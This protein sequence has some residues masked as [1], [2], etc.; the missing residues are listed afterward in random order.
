MNER[1]LTHI[2][3]V[4]L[5]AGLALFVGLIVY[6]DAAEVGAA[7]SVAGGGVVIVALFH[8]LPIGLDAIG[9]WC[10][11]PARER[12]RIR[13][14]VFARWIGYS[15]NGLLPVMQVGGNVVRA[16]LLARRGVPGVL[17][18][19]SVVVDVTTLVFSQ[20][21]FALLGFALLFA[22]LGAATPALPVVTGIGFMAVLV[23]AFYVAQRRGLFGGLIHNLERVVRV[24]GWFSASAEALDGAV[25]VLYARRRATTAATAWHLVSWVVG[26]G[27]VWIALHLL[28]RPTTFTTALLIESLGQVVRSLGFAIPGA[29]GVQEA[30]YVVLGRMADLG[31]ETSLALSL[32]QRVRDLLLGLPGLLVWWLEG[33]MTISQVAESRG[34][35]G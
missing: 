2:P 12:P 5:L 31:P 10:V 3:Y 17:A 33:A 28:G 1:R 29:L 8:L 25:R 22:R 26:A 18:A 15:V 4:G 14:F 30:G 34:G 9:W 11:V 23:T 32:V 13:V 16:R 24:G 7:L 20:V 6:H 19:A 35:P 27:E 21:L